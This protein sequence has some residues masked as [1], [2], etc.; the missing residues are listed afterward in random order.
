MTTPPLITSLHTQHY[1]RDVNAY[2]SSL[3]QGQHNDLTPSQATVLVLA[4]RDVAK[5]LCLALQPTCVT[6]FS[7]SDWLASLSTPFLKRHVFLLLLCSR[8]CQ[9]TTL[10]S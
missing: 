10:F 2:I 5:Q 8:S 1:Y 4:K 6:T 3:V 9:A 7:A